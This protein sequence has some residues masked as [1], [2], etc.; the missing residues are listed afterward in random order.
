MVRHADSPQVRVRRR[1]FLGGSI[2]S[3]SLLFGGFGWREEEIWEKDEDAPMTASEV[4]RGMPELEAQWQTIGEQFSSNFMKSQ[5][6]AI[7]RA[8]VEAGVG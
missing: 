2:A 7:D 4:M 3:I 8:I 1:S 6:Q 5:A